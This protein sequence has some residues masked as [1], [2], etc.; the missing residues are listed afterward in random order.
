MCL[1]LLCQHWWQSY[2]VACA[3]AVGRN[4]SLNSY[5]MIHKYFSSDDPNLSKELLIWKA[6]FLKAWT[7]I[8]KGSKCLHSCVTADAFC[9]WTWALWNK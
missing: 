4:Y 2:R 8:S 1:K 6:T 7:L 3:V 9:I 5:C